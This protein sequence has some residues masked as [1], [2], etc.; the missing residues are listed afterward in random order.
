MIIEIVGKIHT[1]THTQKKKKSFFF[2]KTHFSLS[3]H[4]VV[5]S[6]WGWVSSTPGVYRRDMRTSSS[7]RSINEA[8]KSKVTTYPCVII[9]NFCSSHDWHSTFFCASDSKIAFQ[10]TNSSLFQLMSLNEHPSKVSWEGEKCHWSFFVCLFVFLFV[11][12]CL[13]FF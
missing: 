5:S 13:F 9:R 8:Q 11:F 7:A 4:L 12:V 1:H 2:I 10:S 3:F 6:C